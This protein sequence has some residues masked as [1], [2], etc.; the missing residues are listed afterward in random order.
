MLQRHELSVQQGCCFTQRHFFTMSHLI[1]GLLPT[2]VLGIG[3]LAA[4]QNP[5]TTPGP[6][7]P[8]AQCD[9]ISTAAKSGRQLSIHHAA[10]SGDEAVSEGSADPQ[11]G[12]EAA[13]HL[14]LSIHTTASDTPP[15][16][17]GQFCRRERPNQNAL[18]TA[19]PPSRSNETSGTGESHPRPPV[20]ALTERVSTD[21]PLALAQASEP[22][23]PAPDAVPS[24][25]AQTSQPP[26][27]VPIAS[28]TNG[29]VTIHASGE[30]LAEV[31]EAVR[32]VTGVKINMPADGDS[33]PVFMNLGPTSTR[34][35]LVAL[36]DGTRFNYII[37]G[38]P[39]DL[40]HVS[41]VILSTRSKSDEGSTVATA[42]G[43]PSVQP[44]LY[45][46]Q[47]YRE[48]A[49]A[50]AIEPAIPNPATQPAE[51]PTS[52]PAGI[53]I[54]QLAAQENKS[55]GQVLDELQKRQ[56]EV[57]DQQAAAAAAAQSQSPPQ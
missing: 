14:K 2:L 45:G 35:A 23:P 32:T 48:D 8:A 12:T 56:L 24:Q 46:G 53:N 37:V 42:G 39:T 6:A 16:A 28:V 4:G 54:Q 49:D 13:E 36:V 11:T 3:S 15:E 43:T 30:P 26:A 10:A 1:Q 31:L 33:E 19:A 52:V 25:S 55:P 22:P 57:L 17:Q 47:G 9:G 18:H 5:S 29:K 38:S 7:L 40:E 41:E 34:D 27:A 50:A 44:T 20:A 21:P 51:I